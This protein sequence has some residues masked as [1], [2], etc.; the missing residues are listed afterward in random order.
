MI[1][2]EQKKQEAIKREDY[3]TAKLI[4]DQMKKMRDENQWGPQA[5]NKPS[6]NPAEFYKKQKTQNPYEEENEP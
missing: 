1:L 6:G 3:E 4:N 5:S 2:L